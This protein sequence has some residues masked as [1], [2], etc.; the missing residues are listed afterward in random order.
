MLCRRWM[1]RLRRVL[2]LVFGVSMPVELQV[3]KLYCLS[4]AMPT[5]PIR[6]EDASRSDQEIEDALKDGKQLV[7]VHQD[8]RLNYRALDLRTPAN[9][10]IFRIESEVQFVFQHFLRAQKFVGVITPKLIAG[11]SEG[12]AA[13]FGLDYKGQPACLAQSPQLHKQ[14]ALAGDFERVFVIGPVFR[15]EDSYTHR[16]L[17]EFTGLDVEMEIK[18]HYSEVMGIVDRLFVTIFDTLKNE[19]Q[20][21]IQHIPS[22][23]PQQLER[24]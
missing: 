15:A 22:D 7:R 5:L 9:Q 19:C 8:T 17:C 6:I 1:W 11:S 20:P 18:S 2:D 12:G 21:Q 14:M 16:H 3:K 4:R 10:A 13:V 23:T 24:R